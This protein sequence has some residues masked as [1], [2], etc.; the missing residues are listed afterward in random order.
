MKCEALVI[1][2]TRSL[3]CNEQFGVSTVCVSGT[4]SDCQGVEEIIDILTIV[5]IQSAVSRYQFGKMLCT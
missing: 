4:T 5:Y 3:L 2:G 1:P